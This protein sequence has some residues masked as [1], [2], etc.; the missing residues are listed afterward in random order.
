[1]G[2]ESKLVDSYTA[3]EISE[4]GIVVDS[5]FKLSRITIVLVTVALAAALLFVEGA[6]ASQAQSRAVTITQLDISRKVVA[7]TFDAGSD[8]GYASR[9]LDTLKANRVKASFGMTG[10]WAEAHPALLRRMVREGHTVMN[11]TYSHRSFTGSSTGTAPLSYKQRSAELRKTESAVQRI[12]G[13]STKPYFRPP[14]G[15]YDASVLEDVYTLG[16]K[17]NVMW[18]TDSLGWKGYTKKQILKRVLDGRKP[19]AIYLF[20]V[21][22]QSKDGPALQSIISELQKRGYGFVTLNKRH[23]PPL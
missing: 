5:D 12:A 22:S 19:G 9:I 23:L 16:Y 20:H 1:L 6:K 4:G 21:R 18:S 3:R 7:L 14:Y 11:H 10:K 13:V 15:A 2:V 17:Y 8:A